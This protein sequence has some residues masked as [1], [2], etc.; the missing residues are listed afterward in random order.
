MHTCVSTRACTMALCSASS[1]FLP[2]DTDTPSSF[3]LA[4]LLLSRSIT[5]DCSSTRDAEHRSEKVMEGNGCGEMRGRSRTCSSTREAESSER[6]TD[7][8]RTGAGGSTPSIADSLRS[9]PMPASSSPTDGRAYRAAG[10]PSGPAPG[11]TMRGSSPGHTGDERS[12]SSVRGASAIGWG[13]RRC[14]RLGMEAVC[15]AGDAGGV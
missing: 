9:P 2:G 4:I 12:C 8:T 5:E 11:W 6:P 15:E 14:V 1:A 10:A 13:W 7:S 3:L